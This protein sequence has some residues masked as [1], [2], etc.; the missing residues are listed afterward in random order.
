MELILSYENRLYHLP[1]RFKG[2]PNVSNSLELY[3]LVV[4]PFHIDRCLITYCMYL[5]IKLKK[6]C[7]QNVIFQTVGTSYPFIASPVHI[8]VF[9]SA[10]A[11]FCIYT[12]GRL[13]FRI[14]QLLIRIIRHYVTIMKG[15]SFCTT[16]NSTHGTCSNKSRYIFNSHSIS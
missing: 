11:P 14:S 8:L 6:V 16:K 15:H 1:R 7:I 12:Y 10:H 5:N 3:K 2:S 4:E 9:V 13:G